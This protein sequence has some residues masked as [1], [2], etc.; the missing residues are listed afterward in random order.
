M[1][2][3][4]KE[5][6]DSARER[7][8]DD[9]VEP[10]PYLAPCKIVRSFRYI[11]LAGGDTNCLNCD[12]SVDHGKGLRCGFS[13]DCVFLTAHFMQCDLHAVKKE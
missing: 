12:H 7:D 3:K 6:V 1:E 2:D 9:E 8:D 13:S 4:H 5:I 11:K 10:F